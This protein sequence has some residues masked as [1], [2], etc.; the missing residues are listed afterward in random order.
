LNPSSIRQK[1]L[2]DR[3]TGILFTASA[4]LL[5]DRGAGYN[6]RAKKIEGNP[7]HPLNRG[8]LC[9]RGQAGLQVLYNPDRLKNAVRQTGGRDSR[10]FEPL[11][12]AEAL[13]LLKEKIV[14]LSTPNRLAFL[15][16]LMPD[17]LY[18]LA[19]KLLEALGAA[20]P[21]VFDF[22]SALEG[23]LQ[24]CSCP[25]FFSGRRIC[26]FMISP[27]RMWFFRL[28][29]ISSRHGCHLWLRVW[30]LAPCASE[31]WAD[32]GFSF[33][34][35]RAYRQPRRQPMNGSLSDRRRLIAPRSADIVRKARSLATAHT[36]CLQNVDVQMAAASEVLVETPP[37]GK[38]LADAD[39]AV[40]TWGFSRAVKGLSTCWPHKH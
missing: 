6:G 3:R 38:C 15:G 40:A 1:I 25:K 33:N 36:L 32:E 39:R 13:D 22:H 20:P 28:E 24:L 37:V 18:Q 31:G 27:S 14:A 19:S 12:W 4:R 16:G 7:L 34:S 23:D 5:R 29:L 8:K 11:Y 2:P 35:S 21:V 26:Q 17:H 30:P 9:A 10:H